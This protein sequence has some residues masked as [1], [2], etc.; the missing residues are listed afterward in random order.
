[1]KKAL[2]TAGLAIALACATNAQVGIGIPTSQIDPSAQL[3]V[4]STTKGF[5]PPTMTEAQR[6]AIASP[7]Q[8]LMIFCTDCGEGGQPQFYNGSSWRDML[9]GATIASITTHTCG[10][11]NIHN[12]S[13]TYGSMTDQQGN[14]YKT[15]VI[16][17]QE[18]MAENLNTSIYRNGEAIATNLND[19][20]WQ[21]TSSGAW[22]YYNNDVSL[23]CPYGKLYNWYA[24]GDTRNLCPVG[25]HVPTDGEWTVLTNYLGGEG[26][27]GGNM[28]TTGTIEAATGLWYDPNAEATNNSG[29]SGAPGGKRNF[30]GEYSYIGSSGVWWSSSQSYSDSAW[31]RT[32]LNNLGFV[33]T[34]DHLKENGFSVR[35]VRD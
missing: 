17:T 31:G 30:S 18:W 6:N 28:K 22:A 8:G 7:A 3:Q 11:A 34:D 12:P 24:V 26:G 29:F 1:M 19:A 14:V 23:A 25:W 35:C 9:G 33:S 16:D 21:G 4:S 15:I 5:L 32:L 20:V 13:L 27:A 2:F 10:T